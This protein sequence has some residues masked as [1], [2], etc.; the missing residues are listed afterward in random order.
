MGINFGTLEDPTQMIDS[1][2]QLH[3]DGHLKTLFPVLADGIR[4]NNTADINTHCLRIVRILLVACVNRDEENLIHPAALNA[5]LKR[6]TSADRLQSLLAIYL[7]IKAPNTG[8]SWLN[9]L[10][11]S[12]DK[13]VNIMQYFIID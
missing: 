9:S 8:Q 6:L 2:E 5:P 3:E 13:V 10:C 1:F 7:F 4:Y 11:G 12:T